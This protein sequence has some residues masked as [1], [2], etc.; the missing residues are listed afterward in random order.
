[1]LN[2]LNMLLQNIDY[3]KKPGEKSDD[4]IDCLRQEASK[5]AC[6]LDAPSCTKTA[7]IKLQQY[8]I[9]PKTNK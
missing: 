9:S 7:L 3:D 8:F 6:V 2:S 5:W 4:L 1:M